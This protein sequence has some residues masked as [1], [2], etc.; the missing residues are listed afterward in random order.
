[1][2]VE[3]RTGG[4]L[5]RSDDSIAAPS[6]HERQLGEVLEVVRKNVKCDV[7]PR[8]LRLRSSGID[9]SHPLFISAKKLGRKM[10]GSPTTSDQALIPAPS[11]KVGPGD[12]ARSHSADEFIYLNEI[13]AGI[14][15]YIK[16]IEGL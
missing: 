7:T 14:D 6:G 11:I 10:Y 16:I 2:H 9:P 15:T 8:S 5:E 4:A 1:M 13:Q 12:S 3:R